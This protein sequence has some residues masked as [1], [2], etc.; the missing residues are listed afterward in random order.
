MLESEDFINSVNN[1]GDQLGYNRVGSVEGTAGENFKAHSRKNRHRDRAPGQDLKQDSAL[2]MNSS[3]ATIDAV[4]QF[5][6]EAMAKLANPPRSVILAGAICVIIL[7]TEADIPAD[8]SWG[9]LL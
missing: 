8:V 3:H 9:S 1:Y 4:S 6:L 5:D 7:S 2:S